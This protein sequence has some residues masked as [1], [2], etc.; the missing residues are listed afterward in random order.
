MCVVSNGVGDC[1]CLYNIIMMYYPPG[2]GAHMLRVVVIFVPLPW[3]HPNSCP[4][5]R[6]VSVVETVH[7]EIE[8]P[9][10]FWEEESGHGQRFW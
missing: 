4:Q 1:G 7:D 9:D 10:R 5:I 3:V 2:I 8:R 6:R